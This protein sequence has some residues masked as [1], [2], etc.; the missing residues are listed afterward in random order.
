LQSFYRTWL[1][2]EHCGHFG[3][4]KIRNESKYDD[5][6]LFF[7]KRRKQLRDSIATH[8]GE[9]IGFGVARCGR[10]IFV[11]AEVDEVATALGSECVDDLVASNA[12]YPA[13]KID[14]VAFE[15]VE[16][17][18]GTEKDFIDNFVGFG[19]AATP[20]ECCDRPFEP[21]EEARECPALS[22]QGC[23]EDNLKRFLGTS[24]SH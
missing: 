12:E 9:S 24:V 11:R 14:L 8:F 23:L 3:Y 1:L 5:V 17:S 22:G 19:A 20:N 6:T 2:I 7:G 15:P 10:K 18:E 21:C 16:A 13:T 4:G